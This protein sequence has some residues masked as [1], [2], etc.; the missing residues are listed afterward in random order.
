MPALAKTRSLANGSGYVSGNDRVVKWY[1]DKAPAFDEEVKMKGKHTQFKGRSVISLL[2]AVLILVVAVSPVLAEE[3]AGGGSGPGRS[4]VVVLDEAMGF[5][6]LKASYHTPVSG[7]TSTFAPIADEERG[8]VSLKGAQ[9]GSAAVVSAV[10]SDEDMGYLSLQVARSTSVTAGSPASAR[11]SDEE[12]GFL[13]LKGAQQLRQ[14]PV[15]PSLMVVADDDA[16]GYFSL[17]VARQ[18][19]ASH[20]PQALAHV[21]QR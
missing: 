10:T 14:P 16:M 9:P 15:G 13:C 8:F 4:Q 2:V 7:E 19:Y 5:L 11:L 17:Q 6:S 18:F 20:A 3:D 12:M 1:Q 21:G